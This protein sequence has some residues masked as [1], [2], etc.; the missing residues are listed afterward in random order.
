MERA[1]YRKTNRISV[2][3]DIETYSR[4]NELAAKDDLPIAWIVR[5]AVRDLL[6]GG[7]GENPTNSPLE[8]VRE[9]A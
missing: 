8:K 9:G 5:R 3:F 4:L 7:R 6:D 1:N 2:S